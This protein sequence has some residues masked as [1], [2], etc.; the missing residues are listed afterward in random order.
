MAT[1]FWDAHYVLFVDF[2]EEERMIIGEYYS[3]LLNKLTTNG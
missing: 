2:F 3:A 1:V